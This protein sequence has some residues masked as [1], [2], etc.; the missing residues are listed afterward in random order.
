MNLIKTKILLVVTN[1][2]QHDVHFVVFITVSRRFHNLRNKSIQTV[3]IHESLPQFVISPRNR[4][5]VL[6]IHLIE[7]HGG[8]GTVHLQQRFRI[9]LVTVRL[10]PLDSNF[11][12]GRTPVQILFFE[13]REHV[14][15]RLVLRHHGK[16]NTVNHAP[17]TVVKILAIHR[18]EQIS[19]GIGHTR[20]RRARYTKLIIVSTLKAHL[21]QNSRVVY[22]HNISPID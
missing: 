5:L 2:R 6:T 7:P 17:N 8:F 12:H 18:V 9:V 10:N 21:I 16:A 14:F 4:V 22:S 3:I 13:Y 11:L 20:L 15:K 19:R 1:Q